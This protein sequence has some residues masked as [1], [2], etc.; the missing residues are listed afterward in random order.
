MTFATAWQVIKTLF[1]VAAK[2]MREK[3]VISY[4]HAANY[5]ILARTEDDLGRFCSN[6]SELSCG[7][8]TYYVV[9]TLYARSLAMLFLTFK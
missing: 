8:M 1:I 9:S 5:V 6:S 2:S 4:H 3:V 7:A